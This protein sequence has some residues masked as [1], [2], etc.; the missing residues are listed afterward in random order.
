MALHAGAFS[1]PYDF[2]KFDHQSTSGEIMAFQDAID[3]AAHQNASAEQHPTV[4]AFHHQLL[5]DFA[6]TTIEPPS[7]HGSS[8]KLAVA[9]ELTSGMRTTS[10]VSSGWNRYL[11]TLASDLVCAFGGAESLFGV[12][13]EI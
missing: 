6:C 11:G 13:L 10:A 5:T 1:L 2:D 4:E 3:H 7:G 9:G 8:G 12:S